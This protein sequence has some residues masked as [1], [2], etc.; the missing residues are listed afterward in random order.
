[1]ILFPATSAW[2][3]ERA[4]AGRRGEYMGAFSLSFGLAFAAGPGLGTWALARFG[5]GVL[6][7]ATAALSVVAAAMLARVA[8]PDGA[9]VR[10]S[11]KA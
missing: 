2:V 5:P 11:A 3:E 4:P 8:G 1:M 7:P 10:A 6:W 9:P